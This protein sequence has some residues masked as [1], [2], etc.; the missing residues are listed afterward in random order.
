MQR[1][2]LRGLGCRRA[3]Y[4]QDHAD[5]T[6]RREPRRDCLCAWPVRGALRHGRAVSPRPGSAR[7]AVPH[8]RRSPGVAA[9]GGPD[10]AAAVAVAQQR[11]G[12][13]RP[14][15]GA[16]GRQPVPDA[17]RD[18][19]IDR[20]LHRGPALVA[21]DRG[22]AL[23]RPLDDPAHRLHRPA[24]RQRAPDVAVDLSYRRGGGAG[25]SAQPGAAGAAPARAVRGD[26]ARSVHRGRGGGLRGGT[27]RGACRR[28]GVRARAAR[29]HGR[30][31]AVRRV[32][33]GG[34]HRARRRLETT[35]TLVPRHSLQ[36]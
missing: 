24:A 32:C 15:A 20:P 17:A 7:A 2:A 19:R 16:R 9:C 26:R 29:A 30:S 36:V 3:R 35:S 10:L 34:S 8:Q 4:R 13:R 14:A 11:G 33:P 22:P 31:S 1:H 5:R 28:R 12:A 18:G 21:G 23:E 6:L 27:L 25:P